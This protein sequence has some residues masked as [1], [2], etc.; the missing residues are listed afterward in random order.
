[1]E[2]VDRMN[3]VIEYVETHLC[4]E[5]S[6]DEVS[7]IIASPYSVFQRSFAQIT[8]IT[9]SE[10]IR[11]RRLT[12]AAYEI[13]NTDNRIID[14][15]MQYGYE[16]ADAFCV[17]FKRMHGI[18]P[19]MVRKTYPQLRFYSRLHFTLTIKGVNEMD[20]RM[21]EK[22]A[23]NIL[24]VRRTTP[25]G[26]GTWAIVKSDGSI[27]K[28]RQ[29]A[30]VDFISLGLC[31]GFGDDGSNDY[32]CGFEYG[33]NEISGFDQYK[34][35]KSTWLVFEAKGAISEGVLKNTWDRI[36]GEFLPQSEYQQR[37]LPTIERY[38]Q[39]DERSD[40]CQVEI[41]IPIAN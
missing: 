16:S 35:P 9:L 37:D 14:I 28:M 27:E 25:Y 15:A 17:A 24:G 12:S 22:D 19:N 2:W 11:R 7:R 23:F 33:G 41:M 40:N 34:C 21:I 26:G 18:A 29:M 20:Y 31:F 4:N 13:Q 5:I 39:W 38:I 32:M 36:Y 10:Y 8:G 1:M 30:G 6:P 3:A